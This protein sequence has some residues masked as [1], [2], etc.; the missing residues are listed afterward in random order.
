VS[1]PRLRP[2]G[3]ANARIDATNLLLPALWAMLIRTARA[4]LAKLQER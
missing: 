2:G 3:M 4:V 1:M